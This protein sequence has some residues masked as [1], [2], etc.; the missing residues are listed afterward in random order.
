MSTT[1][2]IRMLNREADRAATARRRG[3]WLLTPHSKRTSVRFTTPFWKADASIAVFNGDV[4]KG[5]K[6]RSTKL[7]DEVLGAEGWPNEAALMTRAIGE[8]GGASTL[9]EEEM[10]RVNA[11]LT[12]AIAKCDAPWLSR[13]PRI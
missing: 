5:S 9:T 10:Q 8:L 4:M 3:R 13:R 11:V 2:L 1:I 12:E 7:I 6:N